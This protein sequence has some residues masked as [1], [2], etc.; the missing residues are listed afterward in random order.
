MA[1]AYDLIGHFA[2]VNLQAIATAR[3][4]YINTSI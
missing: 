2:G 3:A 4:I 1:L